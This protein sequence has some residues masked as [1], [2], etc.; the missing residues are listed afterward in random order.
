MDNHANAIRAQKWT[1]IILEC[2]RSGQKK[3]GGPGGP[4]KQVWVLRE[5]APVALNVK[6][7]IS[8]G[9]MTEITDGELTEGMAVITEQRSS[10]SAT[11]AKKP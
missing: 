4:A 8:D 2:N 9:R 7:G 3:A 11:P 1:E 10:A 5:G 6:V